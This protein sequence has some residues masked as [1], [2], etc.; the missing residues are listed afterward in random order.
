[1]KHDHQTRY[2]IIFV[3][4]L[5]AAFLLL[6][7]LLLSAEKEEVQ[8]K[9]EETIE[10]FEKQ[11][12]SNPPPEN[13]ILF[14]GSSSIR[15]WDL[16]KYFPKR[17]MINRGFGG[18]HI[19]DSVEYAHR[20]VLP[21]KPRII[22]F[23]AGDNDIAAGKSPNT[24]LNDF[25]EFVKIV[26]EELPETRIVFIAIKPSIKRWQLAEKMREANA[27]IKGFI[28]RDQRLYFVDIDTPMIGKD[29]HPRK[30][31]FIEDG[32]H[33]NH[34]GYKLWT[35]LVKPYLKKKGSN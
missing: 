19:A 35:K 2:L 33:L 16:D 10:K 4:I 8:N 3:I 13:A 12:Q 24:V 7:L 34:K 17:K 25:K 15:G 9:W 29:G 20:I 14:L 23:Y 30:E 22:V 28:K 6:P 31:L 21:Y 26:H 1:M 11:D 32:L 27:L 5:L 18:S